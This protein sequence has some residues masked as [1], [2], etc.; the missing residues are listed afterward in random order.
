[1][2]SAP[3]NVEKIGHRRTDQKDFIRL[4]SK[5]RVIE[6]KAHSGGPPQKWPRMAAM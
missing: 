2:S 5:R 6:I 4:N 1:V 3:A